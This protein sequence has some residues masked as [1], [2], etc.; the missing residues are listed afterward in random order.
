MTYGFF[1][2]YH[3]LDCDYD[4]QCLDCPHNTEE[5]IEWFR[6][7]KI[8]ER[9]MEFTE[10]EKEMICAIKEMGV[11]RVDYPNSDIDSL[12]AKLLKLIPQEDIS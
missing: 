2:V 10:K 11:T 3:V 8:K 7:G 5:D 12:I 1:C 6:Q 4:G 9:N